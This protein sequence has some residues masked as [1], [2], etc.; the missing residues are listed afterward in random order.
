MKTTNVLFIFIFI[1]NPGSLFWFDLVYKD[2]NEFELM[3]YGSIF[4]LLPLSLLVAKLSGLN[5]WLRI[6]LSFFIGLFISIIL[7]IV[8]Q[9]IFGIGFTGYERHGLYFVVMYS[10][11]GLITPTFWLT[12]LY[13]LGLCYLRNRKRLNDPT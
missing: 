5:F 2:S 11:I 3:L 13:I 7:M 6:L 10:A 4:L 8:S 12:M 1:L 9:I